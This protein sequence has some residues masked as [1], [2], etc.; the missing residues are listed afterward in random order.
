MG[1]AQPFIHLDSQGQRVGSQLYRCRSQGI[2]GLPRIPPLHPF[3]ALLTTT[4]GDIEAPPD[5][6]AYDFLLVLRLNP[7][8]FEGTSTLTLRGRRYGDHFVDFLG[9]SLAVPPAV[10]GPGL[11]PRSLRIQFACAAR[12]R[13]GLSLVGP[14]RFLQSSLQS[15]VLFSQPVLL[16]PQ[17][18]P[19]L[20]QLFLSP[21]PLLLPP[22]QLL[23]LLA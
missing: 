7:L 4:N 2:G 22:P 11:A 1:H 14:L 5:G 19:F 18:F 10:G 23:V 8:D 13:C 15:L 9:N 12:K 6:L 3:V 16:L 21:L 17:P 20:L